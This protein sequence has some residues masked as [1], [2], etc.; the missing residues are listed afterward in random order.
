MEAKSNF[1]PWGERMNNSKKPTKAEVALRFKKQFEHYACL[2]CGMAELS[3][4]LWIDDEELQQW[5][6]REYELE[7]DDALARFRGKGV[8]ELRE[9]LREF[10]TTNAHVAKWLGQI[11]FG[12]TKTAGDDVTVRVWSELNPEEGLKKAKKDPSV[13]TVKKPVA[14]KPAAKSSPK[15]KKTPS[16]KAP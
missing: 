3:G 2:G 8:A 12:D 16:K 4:I 1:L 15:K 6:E 10:A 5:I 11:M 13:K 9:S 14:K 7:Y